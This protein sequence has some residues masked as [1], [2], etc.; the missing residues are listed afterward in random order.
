MRQPPQSP[1]PPRL[2][3]TAALAA[4]GVLGLL[5][6]YSCSLI[7]ESRDVQCQ[8]NMDCTTFNPGATCDM[9]THI[10]VA[11]SSMSSS[12]SSS[13]GT[14]T[15]STTDTGCNEDGGIDGGGCYN[16]SHAGCTAMTND[17][18]ANACGASCVKFDNSVLMGISADGGLPPPPI[19]GPDGGL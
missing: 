19:V 13:G 12:S 9:N 2:L 8:S 15:S 7:V 11:P 6:V 5:V 3:R 4:A 16:T 1:A 18:L 17:Q 14:T 10:C